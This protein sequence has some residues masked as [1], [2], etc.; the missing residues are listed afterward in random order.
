MIGSQIFPQMALHCTAL[1]YSRIV[2]KLDKYELINLSVMC[3]PNELKIK[4]KWPKITK[5]HTEMKIWW[6][7]TTKH[8]AFE[9]ISAHDIQQIPSQGNEITKYL[10]DAKMKEF[11]IN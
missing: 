8:T 11:L 4:N 6:K 1:N 10:R 3:I 5:W 7:I 2:L 9:R